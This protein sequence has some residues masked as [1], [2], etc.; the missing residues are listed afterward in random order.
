MGSHW[1]K[2]IHWVYSEGQYF[3]PRS[4]PLLFLFALWSSQDMTMTLFFP[5]GP[6][7]W[8]QPTVSSNLRNHKGKQMPCPWGWMGNWLTQGSI[9]SLIRF[10]LPVQIVSAWSLAIILASPQPLTYASLLLYYNKSLVFWASTGQLLIFQ[11]QPIHA[12]AS[13]VNRTL[14]AL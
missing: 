10:I 9:V 8:S 5:S 1:R 11:K 3:I 13:A 4:L 6:K 12:K 7:W 2:W 14:W